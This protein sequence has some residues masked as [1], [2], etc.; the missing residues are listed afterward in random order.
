M[1]RS[2][3][4]ARSAVVGTCPAKLAT[5]WLRQLNVSFGSGRERIF[6][7]ELEKVVI[8]KNKREAR[9]TS[10]GLRDNAPGS[11]QLFYPE[12][13]LELKHVTSTALPLE[14]EGIR[15]CVD[16]D[17]KQAQTNSNRKHR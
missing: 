13:V 3:S 17:R 14:G 9:M 1:V 11:L 2:R 12:V 6:L 10:R 16:R 7:I 15:V 5:V 4:R 8:E